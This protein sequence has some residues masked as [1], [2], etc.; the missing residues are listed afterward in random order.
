MCG[1]VSFVNDEAPQLKDNEIQTMMKRIVH[2]G[3]D[4]ANHYVDEHVALGFRRLSFIEQLFLMGKFIILSR[5]VKNWLKLDTFF[6]PMP[7]R[8]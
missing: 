6:E 7:I 5:F 2:R 8:K 1:F 3:P 4:D